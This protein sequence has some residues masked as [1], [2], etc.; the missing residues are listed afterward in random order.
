MK[1]IKPYLYMKACLENEI[2]IYPKG[3][4]T[5]KYKIIVNTK[6]VEKLGDEIYE[7]KPYIKEV[8]IKT[9]KGNKIIN[10]VVPSIW[11]KIDELYKEI[12]IRNNLLKT[13]NNQNI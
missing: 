13:I 5:G 6:G 1:E 8:V 10:K 11:D 9:P 7:D 3:S 2:K 4:N 12:C